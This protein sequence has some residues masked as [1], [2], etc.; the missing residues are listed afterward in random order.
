[1]SHKAIC[2]PNDENFIK[3][4]SFFLGIIN[5]LEKKRPAGYSLL[6]TN[7]RE[8]EMDEKVPIYDS[9]NLLSLVSNDRMRGNGTKLCQGTFRLDIRKK[10]DLL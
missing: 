3:F 1:M 10:N 4:T 9:M 6:S 8:G 2:L 7:S 5:S